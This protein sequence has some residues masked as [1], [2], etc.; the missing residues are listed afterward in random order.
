MKKIPTLPLISIG[1]FVLL[2]SL[3]LPLRLA[4]PLSQVLLDDAGQY[5]APAVHLVQDGMYSLDGVEPYFAREP[6]M[7][8]WLAAIYAIAGIENVT[9]VFIAQGLLLLAA[10][11][12]F[13]RE[14]VQHTGERAAGLSFLL[15]TI[16]APVYHAVFSLYRESLALSLGLLCLTCL[17]HLLR[18]KKALSA[19]LAGMF[20][21]AMALTYATFLLL[22]VI[23]F[24][25]LLFVRVR[26]QYLLLAAATMALVLAPWGIRNMRHTG[27]LCLTGCN[28]AAVQWYVRGVQSKEVHGLEPLRCLYSEYISRDW[29]GRSAYCSFNGVM[30]VRWPEGFKALPEDR[31]AGKEGL[32]MIAANPVNYLWL[33][34]FEVLE[35]H[36]PYVNGWG[37]IYNL[38]SIL[39][40][41]I[42]YF[43]ALFSLPVLFARK[44]FALVL[45][46]V[47]A[48]HTAVFALTDATPRYLLPVL[49]C[50]TALSGVGFSRLFSRMLRWNA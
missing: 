25:V 29:T 47:I 37:F 12:F 16:V 26:W 19:A 6:G 4:L 28:R 31:A 46:A 45:L 22:P 34:L 13:T 30:H 20:L 18:T 33:S 21:G 23:L 2:W 32:Q 11:I 3:L 8:V 38:L 50:Y 24:P 43:G 9:A 48:Y 49:F 39:G 14:F 35:L 10:A 7:S 42:V 41:F 44:P 36:L 40:M 27:S 15:L 5:S 17:L 1:L